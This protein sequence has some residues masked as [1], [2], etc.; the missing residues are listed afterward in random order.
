MPGDITTTT[1]TT[2]A[3]W[4]L[5]HNANHSRDPDAHV[6]TKLLQSRVVHL[7]RLGVAFVE[8]QQHQLVR[9]DRANHLSSGEGWRGSK[10]NIKA[11]I[12]VDVITMFS[13]YLF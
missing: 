10:N 7:L 1:T 4:W 9:D 12:M 3:V 13:R 8:L 6:M 11:P 5:R 2:T